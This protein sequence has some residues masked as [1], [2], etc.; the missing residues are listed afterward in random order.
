VG[1]D[2]NHPTLK[3]IILDFSSV[4][5]VDVTSVQILIDVRNQLDRYASPETVE[6][7]FA[8][9]NNRWTKRALASAGFGYPA[10]AHQEGELWHRWKPVFSVAELGGFDSAAG[11]AEWQTNQEIQRHSVAAGNVADDVEANA[12]GKTG[13]GVVSAKER[14]VGKSVVTHGVNRPLFHVDLTVALQSAIHNVERREAQG[15]KI[16]VEDVADLQ[17]H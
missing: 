4:N 13:D 8:S 9:I 5:N 15:G 6:W 2:D 1:L 11:Y 14:R 3:A 7:H 16:I 12:N 10:T 17:E